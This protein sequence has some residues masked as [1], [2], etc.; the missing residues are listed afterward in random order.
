MSDDLQEAQQ[1][2][3]NE[4]VTFDAEPDHGLSDPIVLATWTALLQSWQ[5]APPAKILDIGCG[6]GSLSLVLAKL[7]HQVTGIDLSPKMIE[8]A[9]AKADEA[10]MPINFAI[11]GASSPDFPSHS[12]DGIVCRHVLWMLPELTVVL[13][14]W[15][16]LLKPPA[17]LLLVEGFWH[18]GGGLHAE[19]LMA[20]LPASWQNVSVQN[21][22]DQP[23]FW[24]KKVNDERY[25][26]TAE[27][28]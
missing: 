24:G 28:A 4:A 13:Q 18:T 20:A 8:Q 1:Y 23:E 5:P 26:L 27:I 2:W 19:R 7:G 12:F 11:M 6:T 25:A 10:G 14:T 15:T 21:L 16:R 22:S 17:K 9:K 3:D